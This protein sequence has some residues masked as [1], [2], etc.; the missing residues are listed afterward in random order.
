MEEKN[1]EKMYNSIVR[2]LNSTNEAVEKLQK[3]NDELKNG[4]QLLNEKLLNCQKALDINKEI[5]KNALLRQ[6]ELSVSY[7][8]EIQILKDKIKELT[9]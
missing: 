8:N 5:M 9:K 1:Y 4:N 7:A 6:N 2:L 3:E